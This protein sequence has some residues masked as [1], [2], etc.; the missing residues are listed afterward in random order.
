[1]VKKKFIQ[2]IKY[3]A[4]QFD[5]DEKHWHHSVQRTTVNGKIPDFE[6]YSCIIPC[7]RI[8]SI[9][10]GDWIIIDNM[11]NATGVIYK[12]MMNLMN[13]KME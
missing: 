8:M 9:H 7:D 5:P 3:T 12:N 10:P 6:S 2:T 13:I 11:N 4:V 1:M